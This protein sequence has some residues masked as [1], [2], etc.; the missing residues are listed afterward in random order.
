VLQSMRS[1]AKYIWIILIVA[2]VGSFLL[3]ET[4]GLAGRAPVTTTTSIAT[5]NGEEIL[6]TAWQNAVTAL[7]QERSQQ[8]G[9]AITLDERQQLE[10]RA[11]NELVTEL[12]LQQEY[13][14]R[15]ITVTDDEIL[16]AARLAP[17]P[18]A[19]QSPDLQTDG[20]FDIQ[21]YQRFLSSPLARQSGA[22]AGLEAYYRT[23]IPKQKLFDQVASGAYITDERLWQMYRDRHD[24]ATVSYVVLSTAALTDTAV[25]VTDAEISAFYDRNKKRFERPG[26]AVVS[27]LTVTRA[28]TAA[29]S[30]DAKRRIDAIRTEIAG[31]AKFEDVAKR[32]STDTVSGANGGALGKGGKGRFTP[33]FEEAAYALKVGEL[34][35]PVLTP[36]GWHLIRVDARQGDTLDLRHILVNIAQSDSSAT[37]TDRRADSLASKAGSQDD[38]KAFDAAAKQL[39]L[40]AASAVVLEKEPLSFA[41]RYVPSVSAWAFSGVRAG[42]TSDLFDSPDAYY[43]AR[44][45]SLTKGGLAPLAEVKGDIRRRLARDKRV[46]KLRPMGEQLARAARASSLEAVAAERKLTVE[47]SAP[48]TRVDAVPGLGQYTQAVGA[49]FVAPT[50]QVTGPFNA[51]DA[52]VVMRVDARTESSRQTFEAEK[53]IQRQQY[54]QSARQQKVDE[55]LTSLRE[56]V[57]VEDRRSEVLSA[58]RR[59][60]DS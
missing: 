35:Q 31:G 24:S 53:S 20:K 33:K 49:A 50:G 43:L 21:K 55:F 12:L 2:F 57:K 29:D 8:T 44:L 40:T 27:L 34:S 5:V 58:L 10:E 56:S 39:G 48:F 51:V 30:A 17:P 14:R 28:I 18:Q 52:M 60:S 16:Q 36:F 3:Y 15:G 46:E 32:S 26:R 4:S 59:Q 7:E 41:G 11:F 19:M 1:A 37:R 42:E 6:L 38:P 54:L 47:K 9:N 23:E 13:K 25:T 45:D 22:L